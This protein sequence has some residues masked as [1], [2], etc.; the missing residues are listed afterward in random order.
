LFANDADFTVQTTDSGTT[1][2][3]YKPGPDNGNDVYAD[4]YH[5]NIGGNQ[6][7]IPELPV[8]AWIYEGYIFTRSF[9]KFPKLYKFPDTTHIVS[10]K[11][12]LYPPKDFLNHPQGNTGANESLVQRI[13]SKNWLEDTLTWANQPQGV[14]TDDEVII[15]ATTNQYGY[16]PVVDMTVP[17]SKMIA[18]EVHNYGF[19]IKLTN[20]TPNAAVNFA[21]SEAVD[22]GRRPMLQI[23]YK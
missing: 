17:V 4:F 1:I 6:N 20:E 10:V 8:N 23:E 19:R 13:T 14:S 12:Y 22:A 11:L 18:R 21:S 2:V 16:S 7:L 9:I 15:P 5:N 3:N